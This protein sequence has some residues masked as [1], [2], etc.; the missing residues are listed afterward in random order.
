MKI[1]IVG[2]GKIGFAL[3]ERLAKDGHDVVVIDR[4]PRVLEEC[5]QAADVMAIQ[6][7]GASMDVLKEA[8]I[9]NAELLIAAT[10]SDEINILC[11]IMAGK[12]SKV[13][14]IARVRSPE[15]SK[16]LN[17]LKDEMGLSMTFS[18][19]FETA[20][21]ISTLLQFPSFLKRDRFAN[22]RVEIVE[23]KIPKG[24]VLCDQPLSK[25]YELIKVRVLVC[26]VER[27]NTAYIPSGSFTLHENDNIYV[28][29]GSKYLTQLIK[30]LGLMRERI[31]QVMIIGGSRSACSLASQVIG[32]GVGVTIIEQSTER[33]NELAALLPKANVI[34]GDG[35]R[36]NVLDE[37]GISTADALVTLTNLDEENLIIALSAVQK[38]VPKVIAKVNRT[39]LIDSFRI[40]G[41]FTFINP[42]QLSCARVVRYVRA[43][44]NTSGGSVQALH[45]IVGGRAE[46]LEFVVS[47]STRN[48]GVPLADMQIR[49]NIL[50]ASI[51]RGSHTI[52]PSG[53][54]SFN[55]GDTVVVVTLAENVILD[56]NEIFA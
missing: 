27:D 6:G 15:Y 9:A 35:S 51:S 41:V 20:M 36:R 18:P 38:G 28:T 13:H 22:G 17:F 42:K 52:I 11:C 32:A 5:Q 44:G 8:G 23:I 40:L 55:I 31:K 3:T 47:R 19:E 48:R 14:T 30:N 46:A 4:D 45:Y 56:L 16:Q 53:I 12:L 1:I 54:D 10:S 49:D 34:E 39:E 37:E 7:N 50:I 25:L 24:S 26:A 43:M 29:A 33:C 2:D 21:E